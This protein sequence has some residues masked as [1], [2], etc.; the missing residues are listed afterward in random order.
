MAIQVVLLVPEFLSGNDRVDELNR[1]T[2]RDLLAVQGMVPEF[3][4]V[5]HPAITS[6]APAASSEQDKYFEAEADLASEALLDVLNDGHTLFRLLDS[7]GDPVYLIRILPSGEVRCAFPSTDGGWY[8]Y[9]VQ[10]GD[11][12]RALEEV[13]QDPEPNDDKDAI[14]VLIDLESSEKEMPFT[15][16]VV[17]LG[18]NGKDLTKS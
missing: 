9:V 7:K 6:A 8:V 12:L 5:S 13:A 18:W 3:I 10:K 14:K 15:H 11:L 1:E 4:T 2:T 16:M 17:L